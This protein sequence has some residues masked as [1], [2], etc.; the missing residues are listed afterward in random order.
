MFISLILAIFILYK[1]M[2]YNNIRNIILFFFFV[3]L[4]I[5]II[6]QLNLARVGISDGLYGSDARLYYETAKAFSKGELPVENIF[7]FNGPLY[8]L[9]NYLF[10]ITSS[11][12]P[13]NL[14]VFMIKIANILFMLLFSINI[15]VFSLR[16]MR[17]EKKAVFLVIL[18]LISGGFIYT[19]I[20][21]LKEILLL[22]LFSEAL[23]LIDI[24]KFSISSLT[25]LVLL[26]FCLHYIKPLSFIPFILAFLIKL[27]R[28]KK[29]IILF[30]FISLIF[31]F[32]KFTKYW[33]Y[34]QYQ[35]FT[36]EFYSYS[37]TNT[38]IIII[39][40]E[41]GFIQ[42]LI[43]AVIFGIPRMLL[44]PSPVRYF[45]E[46]IMDNNRNEKTY[47]EGV[48]TY[49][50][51]LSQ[52]ILWWYMVLPLFF[53]NLF[54]EI[55]M[56]DFSIKVFFIFFLILYSIKLLGSV[57][58]REKLFIYFPI[59]YLVVKNLPNKLIESNL[60]KLLFIYLVIGLFDLIWTVLNLY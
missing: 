39:Y 30:L 20:R 54:K 32:G 18:L 35:Y 8:V 58:I 42:N 21:N 34:L 60:F 25:L 6:F 2:R 1:L 37:Q 33:E 53:L 43:R 4:I 48:E 41:R 23:L 16:S 47:Y 44:L 38:G 28:S 14:I 19:S 22:Y 12:L 56:K 51:K 46:I 31:G 7:N 27:E 3:Y 15:Y 9:W 17:D 57:D 50:L 24:R 29:L 26:S 59:Y 40:K 10:I 49:I 5:L 55:N 36:E 11:F 13:D 45:T 52:Y